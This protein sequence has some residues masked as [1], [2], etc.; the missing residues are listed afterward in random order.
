MNRRALI[1]V[2]EDDH[3]DQEI[4]EEIFGRLDNKNKVIFFSDGHKAPGFL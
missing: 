4:L 1:I 2:I 3:D